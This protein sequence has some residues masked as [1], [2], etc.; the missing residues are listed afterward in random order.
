MKL[1]LF[2]V[3]GLRHTTGY[4]RLEIALLNGFLDAGLHVRVYSAGDIN[5]FVGSPHWAEEF[6]DMPRRWLYTM[7]E[8]DKVSA[9]WVE[10][11]NQYF[12]RVFVPCP[13]LVDIY[14][15][16]GVTVPVDYLPMGVDQDAPEY[17]ERK[18]NPERWTFLTYSLGDMR[19]GAELAIF[20]FLRCFGGDERYRLI[21]KCR[22]DARWLTGLQDKQIHV[23]LGEQ[24][25]ASWNKL[26]QDANAFIFATRGEGWGLPSREAVLSGLPTITTQALGQW[27]ADKWAYALPVKEMR[28][29][30]FDFWE[31]NAEGSRWFEPDGCMIDTHLKAIVADYPKALEQARTGRAYLLESF[32]W[33]QV[34]KEW[35]AWLSR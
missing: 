32:T 13:P 9:E 20:A 4:G 34:I 3:N 12:E 25:S 5:L 18:P 17:V 14:R 30:Q 23:C 31:A 35:C 10:S 16:S 28:P 27:D 21:I 11:I 2:P 8:A 19:K 29:A 7:S 26:M 22:D 1:G 6:P 33:K 24:D 15:D